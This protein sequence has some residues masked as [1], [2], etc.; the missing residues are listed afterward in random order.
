MQDR[1]QV[2]TVLLDGGPRNPCR[3]GPSKV[4]LYQSIRY[5]PGH[6]WILGHIN[7]FKILEVILIET[8]IVIYTKFEF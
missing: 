1:F 3:T 7:I 8:I 5:D 2:W 4:T 6:I